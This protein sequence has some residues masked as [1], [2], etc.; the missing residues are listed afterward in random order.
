M[1]A[2]WKQ[3]RVFKGLTERRLKPIVIDLSLSTHQ[4]AILIFMV[5]TAIVLIMTAIGCYK[6]YNYTESVRFCGVTCHRIMKP[7]YTT[8]ND[9][10]HAR[11]KCVECHVGSGAG[12]YVHYK[13]AGTRMVLKLLMARM[14]VRFQPLLRPCDRQKKP[15][16]N[17][18]GRENLLA[19]S[20]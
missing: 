18:I 15:V 12:W 3:R 1:G 4:N 20:N 14:P 17:A 10:P 9:S 13:M 6:A 11:V 19:L 2:R 8:H 5:G 16:N 7:E